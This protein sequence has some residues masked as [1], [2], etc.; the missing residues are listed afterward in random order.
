MG[1]PAKPTVDIACADAIQIDAPPKEER[2]LR[3]QLRK[4]ALAKPLQNC[5]DYRVKLT[6][7][8]AQGWFVQM[9]REAPTRTF[10]R[11]VAKLTYAATW[12][13]AW[14]NSGFA[15]PQDESAGEPIPPKS[16]PVSLAAPVPLAA[17]STATPIP[18]LL[19]V[20]P[21]GIMTSRGYGLLG[22]AA[23]FGLP[24]RRT[25][26][27]GVELGAATQIGMS[28]SEFRRVYWVGP[29]V[30]AT[31]SLSRRV[32]LR[33]AV[34]LGVMGV[35]AS[36]STQLG[37]SVGGYTS[38]V[39]ALEFDLTSSLSASAGIE[40]RLFFEHLFGAARTAVTQTQTEVDD[41]ETEITSSSSMAAPDLGLLWC[42]VR[43]GVLWRF[44]AI[45]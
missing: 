3:R 18:V 20:E 45:P 24:A 26:F 30:G 17:E 8:G 43:L 5:S 12:V 42:A 23:Y 9:F 16:A 22:G 11:E 33:P 31:F 32:R 4:G 7:A 34:S 25:P 15:E 28:G 41:G 1:T 21:M 29:L 39:G 36:T 2:E 37:H 35:A 38:I 40:S 6:R 27:L 44:G 13:E 10:E 19:G 14:L